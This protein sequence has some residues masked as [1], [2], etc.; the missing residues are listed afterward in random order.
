MDDVEGWKKRREGKLVEMYCMRK[1]SIL[2]EREKERGG[3][4]GDFLLRHKREKMQ[5]NI[6]LELKTKMKLSEK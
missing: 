2:I 4:S 6:L 1:E 3:S 5:R